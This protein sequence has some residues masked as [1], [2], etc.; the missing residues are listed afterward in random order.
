MQQRAPQFLVL[1]D[2]EYR[3]FRQ[4]LAALWETDPPAQ[5]L[6]LYHSRAWPK[7]Q[8][9][10]PGV[11]TSLLFH[12]SLMLFLVRVPFSLF[13][14]HAS[15]VSKAEERHIHQ[16]V[17]VLRPPKLS[18]YI[19]AVKPKGPGGK[20]G[21]GSLPDRPPARGGTAFHPKLTIISNP[22][23]PDNTRQTIVQLSS[24]PELKIP[25]ELRLPNVLTGGTLP[26]P[27]RPQPAPPATPVPPPSANP[28]V[29]PPLPTSL[30]TTPTLALP[31]Q[32][33]PL[34]NPLLPVSA[35]PPAA[36]TESSQT[37]E[38]TSIADLGLRADTSGASGLLSLSVEPGPAAESVALPPGNR[39]GAFSISP[40][41]GKEG[42]PGGIPSGDERGGSVGNSTGGDASSGVGPGG[43]GGGGGRSA[44]V[45]EGV[46]ISGRN[47][48]ESGLLASFL[49]SGLVYP[50]KPPQ[51]RRAAMVVTAGPTGGGGLQAYGVLK[52]G[53]IYTVYLPMPGRNWVLQYCAHTDPPG[54]RQ[55][56]SPQSIEIRLDPGIVPPSAE[57]QFDFQ[58]PHLSKSSANGKEMIIL[59]GIIREDGSVGELK[60][61]QGLLAAVDQAAVAAFSGWK[62]RPALRSDRP[63]AVEVLVG[64]PL[65]LPATYQ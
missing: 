15:A 3:S 23:R 29:P 35:A 17:Y 14:L 20:P 46:S 42:S 47:G 18:D 10:V 49:A 48:T 37:K 50:V 16:I 43:E 24:P 65:I 7:D 8:R 9:L 22:P 30:P 4:A 39:L 1:E 12:F 27:P 5:S 13:L 64:I 45:S 40:A 26:E 57:E 28:V 34:P 31:A 54:S 60:V 32:P 33:N 38:A 61:L 63:I 55:A 59:Q 62:F 53:K 52:G 58:R 56:R 19:P 44:T 11:F 41:G 51:P 36:P 6:G 2:R 21:Q 25:R